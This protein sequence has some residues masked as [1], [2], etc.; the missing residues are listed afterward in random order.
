MAAR[1]GFV[2]AACALAWLSAGCVTVQEPK[3]RPTPLE[4]AYEASSSEM[5]LQFLNTWRQALKPQ[6]A[7]SLPD[8]LTRD[9]YAV[10]LA[11]FNPFAL[12]RITHSKHDNDRYAGARFVIVQETI[13]YVVGHPAEAPKYELGNFRPA[14]NFEGVA[15]LYLTPDYRK[16]IFKFLEAGSA[17]AD[18]AATGPAKTEGTRRMDFL[19]RHFRIMPGPWSGWSLATS[20]FITQIVFDESRTTATVYVAVNTRLFVVKMAKEDANWNLLSSKLWLIE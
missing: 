3:P 15:A 19:N 2:I 4:L 7:A 17:S 14:V 5:L 1:A 20:P 16:Q 6:D 10:Y 18:A 11:L 9:V 13:S 8:D 12:D